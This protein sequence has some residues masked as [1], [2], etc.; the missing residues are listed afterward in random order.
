M[1]NMCEYLR[2]INKN[3]KNPWYRWL[4]Q[5]LSLAKKARWLNDDNVI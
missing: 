5:Y 3:I 2:E 4:Q 1:E